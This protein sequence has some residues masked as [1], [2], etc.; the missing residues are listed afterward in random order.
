[1]CNKSL[2]INDYIT[3]NNLDI[4]GITETWLRSS[5][6]ASTIAEIT[7]P[8]YT[9]EHIP[10]PSGGKGG[11]VGLIFRDSFKARKETTCSYSSF[12]HMI[13]TLSHRSCTYTFVVLY[14]TPTVKKNGPTLATFLE[15]FPK[16]LENVLLQRNTLVIIGDFNIHFKNSECL[17]AKS[18]RELLDSVNLVQNVSKPTHQSG[19]ILDLILTRPDQVPSK[20]DVNDIL[21]SDHSAVRFSLP[22]SKPPLPTK[23]VTYRRIKAIDVDTFVADIEKSRL[24]KLQTDD[25]DILA[26]TYNSVLSEVLDHHAPLKTKVITIHPCALGM[27]TRLWQQRKRGGGQRKHGEQLA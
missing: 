4:I 6:P 22:T 7:P 20:V 21:L 15:E 17:Q 14:R 5:T 8:G 18:F 2:A 10:R 16:F 24:F 13:V 9:L 11:G 25:P 1:M 3:E 26:E 27:V 19:H 23:E 12:E